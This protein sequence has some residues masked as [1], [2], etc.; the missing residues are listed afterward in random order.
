MEPVIEVMPEPPIVPPVQA[1]PIPSPVASPS[2]A[3]LMPKKKSRLLLV[4]GGIAVILLSIALGI[5]FF[6]INQSSPTGSGGTSNADNTGSD[7]V[8]P[9]YTNSNFF[10]SLVLP[11]SW[12][13]IK[14]SPLH[15]EQSLF[16]ASDLATLEIT[17]QKTTQSLDEILSVQDEANKNTIKSTKSSQVKVGQYD[18]LEREESWPVM[19]L[20]VTTTYVKISDMLYTFILIPA[21]GK[22]AITSDSVIRDYHSVLSSFALTDT[23]K[24]GLDLKEYMTTKVDVLAYPAFSFKYPQ[25]WVVKDEYIGKDT[26][27]ISIYRNNYEI[28]VTQAPVGA[29]VCL[30]SDSPDF[31]GSSGDL[32]NKQFTQFDRLDGTILRRYFNINEGDKSTIFFCRKDPS[33]PYYSTPTDVGGIAYYVPAKYDN[34]IIKE[35]DEIV[36]SI[37]PVSATPSASPSTSP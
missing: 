21:G 12:T 29:A 8:A 30:F 15:P 28:K 27:T 34:D 35:M 2:S 19:G 7:A 36:K 23:S 16:N 5:V 11:A 17:A 24:L 18:A 22:N 6:N 3:P 33:G 20:Q 9:S 13:E 4:V 26:L 1:P 10:Y 31:Q 14:H 32:R 37:T 25:S